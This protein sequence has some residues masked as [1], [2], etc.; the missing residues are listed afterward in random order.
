MTAK[1]LSPSKN[2]AYKLKTYFISYKI[3]YHLTVETTDH[4]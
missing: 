4:L 2:D 3:S 1:K